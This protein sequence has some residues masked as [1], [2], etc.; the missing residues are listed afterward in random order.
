MVDAFERLSAALAGEYREE[1]FSHFFGTLR[2]AII[3]SQAAISVLRPNE[4]QI[5][6]RPSS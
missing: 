5:S 2:K 4:M 1:V 3:S 6:C